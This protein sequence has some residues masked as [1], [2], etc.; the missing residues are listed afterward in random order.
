MANGWQV[1]EDKD[2]VKRL[3]SGAVK[4][5]VEDKIEPYV[6]S[7]QASTKYQRLPYMISDKEKKKIFRDK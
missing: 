6:P 5:E 7:V 3:K 2:G 4:G 1:K